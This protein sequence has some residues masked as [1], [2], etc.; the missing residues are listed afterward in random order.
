MECGNSKER[1]HWLHTVKQR[2]QIETDYI[3]IREI[4][5]SAAEWNLSGLVLQGSQPREGF[6]GM[7]GIYIQKIRHIRKYFSYQFLKQMIMIPRIYVIR[8]GLTI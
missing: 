3:D 2:W 8:T 7:A 1:M 6:L 5:A 4:S